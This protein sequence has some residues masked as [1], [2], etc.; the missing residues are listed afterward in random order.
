M[1]LLRIVQNVQIKP[2]KMK[3][4]P[5]LQ[6]LRARRSTLGPF[7]I[8]KDNEPGVARLVMR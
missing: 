6:R 2:T 1:F 7:Y 4:L 3:C 8:N 5:L